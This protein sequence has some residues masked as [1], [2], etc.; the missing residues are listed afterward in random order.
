MKRIISLIL[1]L[2]M[3]I[4]LVP[5]IAADG[6]GITIV[7]DF[8]GDMLAQGMTYEN[9]T[10]APK[11]T[12]LDYTYTNGFYDFVGGSTDGYGGSS[13]MR[14]RG[15]NIE[16]ADGLYYSIEVYVPKT[17]VYGMVVNHGIS[18]ERGINTNVYVSAKSD[19]PNADTTGKYIYSGDT[20]AGTYSTQDNSGNNNY[21]L[22]KD[23]TLRTADGS[24]DAEISL[25][26]GYYTFTFE[27]NSGNAFNVNAPKYGSVGTFKLIEGN[28]KSS[29]FMGAKLAIDGKKAS[30]TA[31]MS[32]GKT[33]T[34]ANENVVFSVPENS[35]ITIDND[36]NI[37]EVGVGSTTIT[38]TVTLDGYTAKAEGIYIVSDGGITVKYDLGGDMA[39]KGMNYSNGA[40][41]PKLT[42]LD[43]TYTNGFYD[44]VGGSTDG[45]GGS[46]TM[47]YRNQNL[48]V[49][50]TRYY[51][52]EVFVPK[53]GTYNMKMTHGVAKDRGIDTFV[54]VSAKSDTPNQNTT[55]KYDFSGD[56]KTGVYSSLDTTCSDNNYT[57]LRT[58]DVKKLDKTA[59]ASFTLERGY[60]IFTFE[61]DNGV[62]DRQ[63]NAY[64]SVGTFTLISGDGRNSA[65]MGVDLVL[66]RGQAKVEGL[67]SDGKPADVSEYEVT[68]ESDKSSVATVD[69][70][71]GKIT[72]GELGTANITVTVKIDENT[73]PIII[74]KP[75]EVKAGV[76]IFYD[77][78]EFGARNG[79]GWNVMG[80]LPLMSYENTNGFWR[81]AGSTLPDVS[82]NSLN[83][84][85]DGQRAFIRVSGYFAIEVHI[86]V[87]GTYDM[88]LYHGVMQGGDEN[89]KVYFSKGKPSTSA[90]DLIGTVNCKDATIPTSSECRLVSE[91][92]VISGIEITEPGDYIFT[93]QS[94]RLGSFELSSGKGAVVLMG[95][96]LDGIEDGKAQASSGTMSD[97]TKT[98]LEGADIKYSSSDIKVATVDPVTGIITKHATGECEITATVTL[99]GVT[100]VTSKTLKSEIEDSGF[101]IKYDLANFMK[102]NGFASGKTGLLSKISYVNTDGFFKYLS[103]TPSDVDGSGLDYDGGNIAFGAD[104]IVSFEIHVPKDGSY[105]LE[106]LNPELKTGAE[107]EVYINKNSVSTD[108]EDM[109]GRYTFDDY[110][111]AGQRFPVYDIA[112]LNLT[113]GDHVI[114]FKSCGNSGYVSSFNLRTESG[115]PVLMS[116]KLHG[117]DTGIASVTGIMT[118]KSVADLLFA[119]V[120]YSSSDTSVATIDEA[121]GVIQKNGMG[122]TVITADVTLSGALAKASETLVVSIAPSAPMQFSGK[123]AT[124]NFYR[125]SQRWLPPKDENQGVPGEPLDE[126]LSQPKYDN[127]D[128]RMI[129]YKFSAVV[130]RGNWEWY[131][132]N[133]DANAKTA[134]ACEDDDKIDAAR[135]LQLSLT[136]GQWLGLTIEVPAAGRYAMNLEYTGYITSAGIGEM[137]IIP[138]SADISA[139]LTE[140]NRIGEINYLDTTLKNYTVLNKYLGM[141]DFESAGEY[142]LVFKQTGSGNLY[143]RV[144]TLNGI[145]CVN[146]VTARVEKTHLNFGDT[147][148]VELFVRTLDGFFTES[149][150]ASFESSNDKIISVDGDGRITANAEGSAE[151]TA[152][153]T[154]GVGSAST[155]IT[156]TA[157]DNSP[158]VGARFEVPEKMYVNGKAKTSF[159]AILSN[160]NQVDI[161]LDKITYSYSEPGVVEIDADGMATAKNAGTVV[162]TA[163]ATFRNFECEASVEITSVTSDKKKASVYYTEE[164]RL[165][166]LDNVEKYAWARAMQREAITAAQK[167]VENAEQVYLTMPGEG[168]PRGRQVGS[169]GDQHY[170]YCRYCGENIVGKYGASGVGGWQM[171]IYTKMW[172][173]QCPDC[174]RIF[175][176]NDFASFFK[177]G[178]DEQG[179]FDVNRARENHHKML[180]HKDGEECTHEKPEVEGT[181]EWYNFYGY[182]IEGGYLHNDR[183][184]EVASVDSINCGRGLIAAETP[185]RWAVD[186]GWGYIIRNADG[187]QYI[188]PIDG[189]GERHG[190]VA[191]F[192]HNYWYQIRY[193]VE[194]LTEAWLY[195]S[196]EKYGRAGAI[197]ID[198]ISD[199]YPSFEMAP[200]KEIFFNTDGG[201]GRGKHVGNIDDNTNATAFALGADAFYPMIYDTWV[202]N[203]LSEHAENTYHLENKKLS[204]DDI[205]TN[206]ENGLLKE[207]FKAA[208]TYRLAGNY[209][210]AQ[211]AV[212]S[213]ALT[214]D[215]EPETTEM[216]EWIYKTGGKVGYDKVTGGNLE[217][218][219][220]DVI[221]RNGMGNEASP[222]YNQGWLRKLSRMADLLA[223]YKGEKNYNPYD[224]PKFAEMFVS[225]I[226]LVIA[227]SFHA[228]IGDTGATASLDFSGSVD[229]YINGFKNLKDTPYGKRIAQYLYLRNG[230]EVEGLNYGILEQNPERLEDE[231]L[232]LIEEDP[233]PVSEMMTG[234]GFA[235]LR[236]GKN[237][238]SSIS[239]TDKNN[240]RD[241]WI[242][243]GR[244]TGH[245]HFDTLN[246]GLEA[247]GLNLAPDLGYPA[248]TNTDPNR[249]QWVSTTLS[250]NT[251]VV[252]ERNQVGQIHGN[253]LHFDDAGKVKL[254]DIEA[255]EVY[256]QTENYRRTLVMVEVD[257]DVSYGVDFFRVTGGDK[258][259]YSFHSQAENAVAVSGME[260]VP[261]EQIE[262]IVGT[263]QGADVPYGPDPW[264]VA[265]WVY[266][267]KY[268]RGY[269]WLRNVRRDKT[270]AANFS[271]EFEVKDY[272]RA[273]KD[274]SGIRLRMT[275][276]NNFVPDEV[277]IVAGMIP[278]KTANNMMPENFDYVLTQRS[279]KDIDSLFTTVFE[280]YK[281][282]RYVDSIEP[283]KI[284]VKT[285]SENKGDMARAVKVT[286]VSGRVDYIM[287]ATNNSVV[288]TVDDTFDF[289]GFVG[290]YTLNAAGEPIY[291]YV[292]DGD[293]L[294]E[295]TDKVAAYKGKISGFD[296]AFIYGDFSNFI[297]IS[298]ENTQVDAD[299]ISD[300]EGRFIHVDN[301]G[302]E[303]GVYQIKSATD[304]GNGQVRLDIG[305]I[306]LV[307]AHKNPELLSAGGYVFNIAKGQTYSI[308]TSSVDESLP[309]FTTATDG[310]TVTA[311]STFG[312]IV[313]AE[314]P[315]T[316]PPK[317]IEYI[318]TSLPRGMSLD[319]KTGAVSWKPNES[320][321]GENHV[322][323]T[324]RDNDGREKTLHFTVT[325]YGSTTSKPSK[326]NESSDTPSGGGGGG[327]GGGAAPAPDTGENVGDDDESLLLEEKVPSEGEADEVENGDTAN[328][329]FTDL[330][331]HAWA[332][333]AINE[334]AEAGI[335]K[336]TSETTFSPANNITR[337]D[338]AL[339]LVRAFELSSD[340]TENFADVQSSDYFASEL[341]IA[342]NTGI[343]GGIGDNKYA[344]RNTIT[345]Q[346]MM[347]IVYR[348]LRALGIRLE[349]GEA[350]Y[351]DFGEVAPY[352][353]DAVSALISA[354]LVNGKNGRIDPTAYTTRAEVAVLIKRILDYIK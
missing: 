146:N 210:M 128:I 336:G 166:A 76:T 272:R 24:A 295:K 61:A 241:F 159:V 304:L 262:G 208:T 74:T 137:Y 212:A 242:Y 324:A 144:L 277:A 134:L 202:I 345:R 327:G 83:F 213:A 204:S 127:A 293:V 176:S 96:N 259:T 28:G 178:V 108:A 3:L 219:F 169:R 302:V 40:N 171:D 294:V 129:P 50:D 156:I 225:H 72:E 255:P 130:G 341:A 112:T 343:V 113:A 125:I 167:Y 266:E 88:T 141:F 143:P 70:Q 322:A 1:A 240:Q 331:N 153:V 56:T 161:P 27:A 289:S 149:F 150:T 18:K 19:T 186:D 193:I 60:Y 342:R 265:E 308:P 315:I 147:A 151:I 2:S 297:D 91:P 109:V 158:V 305:T 283:V 168:V 216:I 116:A 254:M 337:A 232:E 303:N 177:L 291:K 154:D 190:Y 67:M 209:G 325:V 115:N 237:Y 194:G 203:F 80:K 270:P 95:V 282:D 288:Y 298:I 47:R 64:G 252:D 43:Y 197:I 328:I 260:P 22:L 290:V 94:F 86:P 54:Y 246:L 229:A 263:Y 78:A 77:V 221:D 236:D 92:P 300:L 243:F 226:P 353:K 106:M 162:C 58:S 339:L 132:T 117:V 10:N 329:R 344:P 63:S 84:Y 223:L 157:E 93:F 97:G 333:D 32:D 120:K 131:G 160:G 68:F 311:G 201:S 101:A 114:T 119:D 75:Y 319:S 23:S 206:W 301:D 31:V 7:Y 89:A 257:D 21:T 55:A 287:Y 148:L 279:G 51:S 152:N 217:S 230:L 16:F 121:A 281:G 138:K 321:T 189:K 39:A 222:Q 253:P 314:S 207:I 110:V 163:H 25:E 218:Q 351:P 192:F 33:E 98:D 318:G 309:Y 205:L 231:I 57:T 5:A 52:F 238:E 234:Y 8:G 62:A 256:P 122:E 276:M 49:A 214:L 29:V 332:A 13:T 200:Y 251:V 139:S 261:D 275:Q 280:P 103:S 347:V 107:V 164:G 268:P 46:S 267:T 286:H 73:A 338:F 136:K 85:G 220:V 175:P 274:S 118:D 37:K 65:L 245:G 271:V 224:N 42:T 145:N 87:A 59:N 349:A 48:E 273:V 41:S 9:R 323:I 20:L 320:Q 181:E 278:V 211:E 66:E 172:Q 258:H 100:A 34:V 285:G 310:L 187:S 133:F 123:K 191:Y 183:Y 335:I 182:G 14:Y 35:A 350:A 198:R 12:V 79:F 126:N 233:E 45:Y 249:M 215:H 317:T 244:N 6:D 352:A 180:Y 340:N 30:V 184:P 174:K 69:A 165:A 99:D 26:R 71:S 248:N 173:I 348:A 111:G 312:I 53:S 11:L 292:N 4:S 299:V 102:D 142:V 264:T 155:T 227:N 239:S 250:H 124:Y 296:D 185:E 306:S 316:N 170:N 313:N 196:D 104:K 326:D 82:G 17:G 140:E 269:T 36:G 334:L 284:S 15:K 247:Y 354:G 90:A 44:F 135:F 188:D 307:R 199:V 81:Y 195:T 346:D 228:Q 38:A 330:G 105:T 179:Y 235:V